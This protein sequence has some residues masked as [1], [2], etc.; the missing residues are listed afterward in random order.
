MFTYKN[1][2]LNEI[3]YLSHDFFGKAGALEEDDQRYLTTCHQTHSSDILEIN[4]SYDHSTV[5]K[6]DGMVTSQQGIMLG[7]KTAD[8]VPIL[9]ADKNQPL[10]AAVHAGWKGAF[11]GIA[12]NAIECMVAKGG[13][14]KDL[15]VVL[16][17][18]IHQKSYE[19]DAHFFAH[20]IEQNP[21]NA[22]FFIPSNTAEHYMFSLPDY[23]VHQIKEHAPLLSN[24]DVAPYD[25]YEH[26]DL[27]F[28]YRRATHQGYVETGRQIS[29]LT[30]LD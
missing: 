1:E 22:R 29:C 3:S 25:T 13:M 28:S 16:G 7:I 30:I 9:I 17:P 20:F 5:S 27:F 10:I 8:C 14:L 15:V 26:D 2:S 11:D 19:V 24:I 18:C 12:Q 4:E 23:L 21:I 6:A